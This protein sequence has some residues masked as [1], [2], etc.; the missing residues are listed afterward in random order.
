VLGEWIN[1]WMN[2]WM[3]GFIL[4]D[5]PKRS[6]HLAVSYGKENGWHSRPVFDRLLRIALT[7]NAV[8]LKVTWKYGHTTKSTC[9]WRRINLNL[10]LYYILSLLWQF[11]HNYWVP[12][13]PE[14]TQRHHRRRRQRWLQTIRPRRHSRPRPVLLSPL[15]YTYHL[16]PQLLCPDKKSL[17]Y[18]YGVCLVQ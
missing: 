2:L 10:I 7:I 5:I 13:R 4:R 1:E 14:P 6:R 17:E 12:L 18:V 11:T 16:G 15:W 9:I 3:N 8:L